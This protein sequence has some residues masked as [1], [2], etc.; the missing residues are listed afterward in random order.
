VCVS[1]DPALLETLDRGQT[2]RRY[3][4]GQMEGA[5]LLDWAQ[6]GGSGVW[7][8]PC[9]GIRAHGIICRVSVAI[10]HNGESL[11]NAVE[12]LKLMSFIFASQDIEW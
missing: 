9:G 10:G 5:G 7:S 11:W 4:E 12:C 2:A 6:V 3:L 1:G 8:S